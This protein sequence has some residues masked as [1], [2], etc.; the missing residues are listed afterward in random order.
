[1]MSIQEVEQTKKPVLLLPLR[2]KSFESY[3]F[4]SG[5]RKKSEAPSWLYIIS[6]D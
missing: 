6:K 1:M 4:S 3:I 5:E 2:L